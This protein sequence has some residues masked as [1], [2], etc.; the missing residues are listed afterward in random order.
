MDA[1]LTTNPAWNPAFDAMEMHPGKLAQ[2]VPPPDVTRRLTIARR[3]SIATRRESIAHH[4]DSMSPSA[5]HRRRSSSAAVTKPLFE[6][7]ARAPLLE[8]WLHEKAPL[9]V[10]EALRLGPE[11]AVAL[12]VRRFT[13]S[14]AVLPS[15]FDMR[16][17]VASVV[18]SAPV[19]AAPG[20]TTTTTDGGA[21]AEL[22]MLVPPE[23]LNG[24][25]DGDSDEEGAAGG[26]VTTELSGLSRVAHTSAKSSTP[27]TAA[28][29]SPRTPMS[30]Q[31]SGARWVRQGGGAMLAFDVN[32]GADEAL[33]SPSRSFL[34]GA[35][36]PR[37]LGA[38]RLAR[39]RLSWRDLKPKWNAFAAAASDAATAALAASRA[40]DI[41]AAAAA[42]PPDPPIKLRLH[43]HGPLSCCR[44]SAPHTA[45]PYA[46]VI[47]SSL[48]PSSRGRRRR[49]RRPS[50]IRCTGRRLPSSRPNASRS[51]RHTALLVA[52]RGGELDDN[53]LLLPAAE[54]RHWLL[55]DR[56][57]AAA[58][59][60]ARAARAARRPA[61]RRPHAVDSQS[62]GE[63]GRA[64][65]RRRRRR[66]KR[67]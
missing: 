34:A 23:D 35:R 44:A 53:Y 30:Y 1:E 3:Q 57:P 52:L 39:R 64:A 45:V 15:T 67:R 14:L 40:V 22:I 29:G 50:L 59:S 5:A 55:R 51:L 48:R 20:T 18:A 37:H 47:W 46:W 8:V 24:D 11:V 43:L 6:L 66:C 42:K 61:A 60:H 36:P 58:R 41:Q 31:R 16:I 27:S 9:S 12:Q 65:R 7:D 63:S 56:A 10:A 26:E 4:R 54:R 19:D 38:R 13:M 33:T 62:E 49:R 21:R 25:G 28:G 17:R 32:S 2:R